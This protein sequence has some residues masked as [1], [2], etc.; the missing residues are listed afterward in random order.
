MGTARPRP[1][2]RHVSW[3]VAV[4]LVAGVLALLFPGSGARAAS[5]RS[6]AALYYETQT[7]PTSF[8]ID[9]LD[10]SGKRSSTQ[11]VALREA[12]VYGIALRRR[13]IS[14]STQS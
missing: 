2:A 11:V 9:A 10:L 5:V 8:A 14:W 4:L 13:S 7:G 6:R 3:A 1:T 12:N